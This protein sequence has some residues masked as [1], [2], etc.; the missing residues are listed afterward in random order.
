ML[1][2]FELDDVLA[3]IGRLSFR[4]A[5]TMPQIP[6]EYTV[7]GEENEADYV[8]LHNA[9]RAAGTVEYWHAR[10]VLRGKP[11]ERRSRGV[12]KRYLYPGDGF[13]YWY[14]SKLPGSKIHKPEPDRGR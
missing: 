7:R 1:G 2:E 14:E 8:A 9:I 4:V 5:K 12:A 11:L 13:R 10:R 6:H 3:A